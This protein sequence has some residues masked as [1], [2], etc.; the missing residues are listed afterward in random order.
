M[1]TRMNHKW[2]QLLIVLGLLLSSLAVATPVLAGPP[3]EDV[4]FFDIPKSGGAG[5]QALSPQSPGGI[6]QDDCTSGCNRNWGNGL[7]AG[8]PISANSGAYHFDLPLLSLG[9]PMNLGFHPALPFGL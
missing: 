5:A 4:H 1:F 2:I 8:D 9:G 6:T 7:N 3:P